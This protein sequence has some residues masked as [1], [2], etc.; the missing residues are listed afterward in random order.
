M[1]QIKALEYS[2]SDHKIF[3]FPDFTCLASQVLLLT[4]NS[5]VGKTTLLHLL[6]GMLL[7]RSGEILID[8]YALQ[9][10]SERERDRFRGKYI[11]VVLQQN[12]F[13][14]SFNVLENV[15]MASYFG[16]GKTDIIRAKE[17]LK[18]LGLEDYIYKKTYEL[19]IGQQQRVS[20]AR[21]L[22]NR[23]KVVLADEPTSSLDD[24]NTMIVANLLESIAKEYQT[25]MIVVTH[26]IRLKERFQNQIRLI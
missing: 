24:E 11:G 10:L 18:Y 26:D 2:Y 1:I 7:P 3:Q 4:G 14:E 12:Y 5:G 13:I 23:P 19:S 20:I 6:G 17:I 9:S 25:A 21:A 8:N 22:I 15:L 16:K